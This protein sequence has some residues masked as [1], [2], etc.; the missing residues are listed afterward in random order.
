[1]LAVAVVCGA[2]FAQASPV[3]TPDVFANDA[4][5]NAYY[6]PSGLEYESFGA[7]GRW[8]SNSIGGSTYEYNI[9]LRK[10]D[11]TFQFGAVT[12]Q[13]KWT[14]SQTFRYDWEV[15]YFGDG[16]KTVNWT[17]EGSPTIT[18]NANFGNL[19]ALVI[20]ASTNVS[21][22]A[23]AGTVYTLDLNNFSLTDVDAAVTYLAPAGSQAIAVAPGA[24]TRVDYFGVSGFDFSK[25]WK[26]NGTT[27]FTW[28]GAAPTSQ[29][30][31]NWQIK[32]MNPVAVPEP[33]TLALA[34]CGLG[35]GAVHLVRRRR[36][37]EA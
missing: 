22:S 16:S 21:S 15:E 6:A 11:G 14:D 37:D 7:E 8:G 20:R 3:W 13:K 23:P 36:R 5:F 28:T 2:G 12:G 33:S 25:H 10:T 17:V 24:S 32:A 19:D 18:L 30:A 9:N 31:F 34:A 27:T 1:M 35:I 26:F 29:T 4:A